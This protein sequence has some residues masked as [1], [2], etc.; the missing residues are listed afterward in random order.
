[1]PLE[2]GSGPSLLVDV[3]I[4]ILTLLWSEQLELLAT[5]PSADATLVAGHGCCILLS[6]AK[7]PAL[8]GGTSRSVAL[9]RVLH[10]ATDEGSSDGE[11]FF[12]GLCAR[13][14]VILCLDR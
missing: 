2:E 4:L 3:P 8:K 14:S 13:C 11:H 10:A 9:R 1:M 12:T 6:E 5:S 7:A